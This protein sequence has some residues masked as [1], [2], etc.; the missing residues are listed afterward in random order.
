MRESSRIEGLIPFRGHGVWYC[1]EGDPEMPDKRPLLCLHGGPG[2]TSNY[3]DP[4][5][6]LAAGGRRVIFYDQ[7]GCGRSDR[8]RDASLWS[9]ELFLDELQT[10]RDALGLERV[11]ILGHSWGGM[12]A[13][14]YAASCP[15]GL[16]S[17]IVASSPASMALWEAELDRLRSGL[18]DDVRA[19][20]TRHE[21]EATTADPAYQ[22]AMLAF[23]QRHMCRLEIWPDCVVQSFTELASNPAVQHT[24]YGELHFKVTGALKGWNIADRLAAIRVPTL[25]TSGRHDEAT[26]R[27]MD[28]VHRGIVGSEWV[29]FEESAHLPH[30]EETSRFCSVINAFLDRVEATS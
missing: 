22:E 17:L 24:M 12:L 27:V 16:E 18:P 20:L 1:V 29:V 25:V 9:V 5:R 7:L 23:L 28:E 4:L 3:L 2:A 13:M 30:V 8:P 21:Q 19:V 11:H 15:S 14:A 6:A 26:P 10:V